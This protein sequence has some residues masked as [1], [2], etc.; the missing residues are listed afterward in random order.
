M[1]EEAA[2]KFKQKS[3]KSSGEKSKKSSKKHK[4]SHMSPSHHE[5]P[6]SYEHTDAASTPSSSPM[7][8]SFN[9][10]FLMPKEDA[11]T[12]ASQFANQLA[13]FATVQGDAGQSLSSTVPLK[14]TLPRGTM[15]SFSSGGM[16]L[17]MP[18]SSSEKSVVGNHEETEI[19][20]HMIIDHAS[21]QFLSQM[22]SSFEETL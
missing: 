6:S 21:T 7:Q 18:K 3:S 22:D 15:G 19:S 9:Q 12:A 14:I 20:E 11:A 1:L 2:T 5:I 13:Y 17:P 8:S 4:V 16:A 10:E